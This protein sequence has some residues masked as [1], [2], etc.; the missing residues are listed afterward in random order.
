MSVGAKI[1]PEAEG[2]LHLSC[3]SPLSLMPPGAPFRC[4]RPGR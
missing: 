2:L 1:V 4:L 3:H